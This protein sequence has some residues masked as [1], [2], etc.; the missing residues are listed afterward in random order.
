MRPHIML[1]VLAE[2]WLAA[3]LQAEG[4]ALRHRSQTM[5]FES[6]STMLTEEQ[7]EHASI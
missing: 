3:C 7:D 4:A 1:Q 6:I 5:L 2:V